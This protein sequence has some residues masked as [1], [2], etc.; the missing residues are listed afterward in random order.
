M[1]DLINANFFWRTTCP[2]AQLIIVVIVAKI[3]PP[4]SF[5]FFWKMSAQRK[6][7]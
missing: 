4:K 6:N 2:G 7:G 1:K 5:L 3:T